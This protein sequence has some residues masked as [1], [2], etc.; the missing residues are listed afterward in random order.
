MK[1]TTLTCLKCGTETTGTVCSVGRCEVCGSG[2]LFDMKRV[3]RITRRYTAADTFAA[4][5]E[6]CQP[7]GAD[8]QMYSPSIYGRDVN[9]R[10]NKPKEVLTAALRAAGYRVFDGSRVA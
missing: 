6:M 7:S 9:G 5:C 10:R 3:N 4:L 1:T 8:R 2:D